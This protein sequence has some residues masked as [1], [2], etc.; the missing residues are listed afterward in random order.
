MSK[1]YD[2]L[3]SELRAAAERLAAAHKVKLTP[4]FLDAM[5]DH[6]G[7]FMAIIESL[8]SQSWM[9]GTYLGR[10]EGTE[11]A[12]AEILQ[13]SGAFYAAGQDERARQTRDVVKLLDKP[14]A[15]AAAAWEG[16]RKARAA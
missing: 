14:L 12:R 3:V 7:G 2:E 16:R 15:E 13:Q 1:R 4:A 6:R 5:F 11:A 9:D 10:K 8:D